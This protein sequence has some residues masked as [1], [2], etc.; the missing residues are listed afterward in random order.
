QSL[1]TPGRKYLA[2]QRTA[3]LNLRGIQ[4]CR[5]AHKRKFAFLVHNGPCA[6]GLLTGA[7][8][9]GLGPSIDEDLLGEVRAPEPIRVVVVILDQNLAVVTA[10]W[11]TPL[12]ACVR[13]SSV[14]P[15]IIA[16]VGVAP[17]FAIEIPR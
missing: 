11:I 10:T 9:C 16:L 4:K 15:V 14:E 12:V 17:V 1:T 8:T 6:V 5:D 3:P 13:A 2:T 7:P